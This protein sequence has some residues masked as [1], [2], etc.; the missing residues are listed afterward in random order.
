MAGSYLY[1][2]FFSSFNLEET[3]NKAI[4][5]GADELIDW[6]EDNPFGEFGNFTGSF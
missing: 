5:T 6:G 2:Y 3:I 1:I 4:E